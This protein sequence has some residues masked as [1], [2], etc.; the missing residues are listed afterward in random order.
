MQRARVYKQSFPL[1]HE[2]I[3]MDSEN[4]TKTDFV[5]NHYGKTQI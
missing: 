4:P 2:S 3:S 5:G 1:I